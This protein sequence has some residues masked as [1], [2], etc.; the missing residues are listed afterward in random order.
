MK[1]RRQRQLTKDFP[2]SAVIESYVGRCLIHIR[3]CYAS[4]ELSK[5]F[6]MNDRWDVDA[7]EAASRSLPK[8]YPQNICASEESAVLRYALPK[9]M[10][11]W[12]SYINKFPSGKRSADAS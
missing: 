2:Q 7:C 8:P 3:P 6:W 9:A 1:Q 11:T 10:V 5:L 4:C 12:S